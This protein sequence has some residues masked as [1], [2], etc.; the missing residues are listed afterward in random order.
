M[1][2]VR[3]AAASEVIPPTKDHVRVVRM[4]WTVCLRA[5]PEIPVEALGCRR[6]FRR[7]S[8]VLRP[9][10]A[11]GPVVDLT[12]LADSAAVD[13]GHHLI[14]RSVGVPRHEV[15][16]NAFRLGGVEDKPGLGQTVS[17]R[18]MHH[19]V[20]AVFHGG[21]ADDPVEMIRRHDLDRVEISLFV[22]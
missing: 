10:R 4:V 22:E 5:Q 17:D 8:R 15:R 7:Q 19:H 18:L 9:Y 2:H 3:H 11:V 12:Q 21:D 16:G 14:H 13:P 6:R 1:A 20:L